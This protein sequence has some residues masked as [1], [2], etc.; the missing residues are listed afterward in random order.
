MSA[1]SSVEAAK[2][3][4][5]LLPSASSS[6]LPASYRFAEAALL[7][8]FAFLSLLHLPKHGLHGLFLTPRGPQ[9]VQLQYGLQVNPRLTSAYCY[10]AVCRPAAGLCDVAEVCTA[11]GT[12]PQDSF[13]VAGTLCRWVACYLASGYSTVQYITV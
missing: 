2:H 9:Q 12:C 3:H 5:A 7:L 8:L 6:S 13:V 11:N 4:R 1:A 10:L